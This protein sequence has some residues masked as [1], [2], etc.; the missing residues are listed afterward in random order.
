MALLGGGEAAS[1][2]FTAWWR[3][4]WPWLV[5]SAAVTGAAV[6]IFAAVALVDAA[7]ATGRPAAARHPQAGPLAARRAAFAKR[8]Q[9][10]TSERANQARGGL[11]N[12]SGALQW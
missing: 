8:R 10:A 12:P 7:E 1:V 9:L 6:V 11:D 3:G 5:A 2:I 4:W